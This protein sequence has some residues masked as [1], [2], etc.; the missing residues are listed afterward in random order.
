MEAVSEVKNLTG[1]TGEVLTQ[2]IEYCAQKVRLDNSQTVI[3]R[4]RQGD[5]NVCEY[6]N[7]SL[8]SQVAASLGALDEN[9]RAAYI[10]DYEALPEDPSFGEGER[11]LPI[12]L[13][14]WTN[15]KTAALNS[16]VESWDRA[17]TQRYAELVGG[18]QPAH[19]LDVQVVDSTDVVK[20]IGYGAMLTSLHHPPT[21]VWKR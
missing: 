19:L 10:Y 17:L 7:Y 20:R 16:V 18:R 6:C 13:I 8:A 15:R 21:E 4:L 9:V 12:H 14:V 11:T 3:D 2:A 5:G 1:I